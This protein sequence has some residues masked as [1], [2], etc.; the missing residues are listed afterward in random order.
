MTADRRPLLVGWVTPHIHYVIGRDPVLI[1][2]T[3]T[4][5]PALSAGSFKFGEQEREITLP[6]TLGDLTCGGGN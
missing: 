4:G 1:A 5:L 2:A 3:T 6:R